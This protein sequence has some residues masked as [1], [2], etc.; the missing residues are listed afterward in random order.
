MRSTAILLLLLLG[1][2]LAPSLHAET[3]QMGKINQ[4]IQKEKEMKNRQEMNKKGQKPTAKQIYQKAEQSLKHADY[5]D[6]LSKFDRIQADY[7]FSP[8]ATQAQ[9]ESIYANYLARKPESALADASRF[10]REHPRYPNVQYV[11]YLKG[12]INF[13]R[14]VD[15]SNHFL[16]IDGAR[17][18]D[19]YVQQA[20]QDFGQLIQRY[21]KSR[22][23]ADARQ[24]MIFLKNEMAR[25]QWY[26]AHY[27]MRRGAWLAANRRAQGI[28]KHYQGTVWVPKALKIMEESYS[29]LGLK[30]AAANVR[31]VMKF[32]FPKQARSSGQKTQAG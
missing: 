12:L 27:Y 16:G 28:V 11:Y 25:R 7:P 19:T 20:F 18:D 15:Q 6:A 1:F 24:R 8:Y 2:A 14:A 3:T 9:M 23:A 22:Y 30:K 10:L 5:Q 17:R 13:T 4:R 32:N 29:K 31:K 21:P 26:I